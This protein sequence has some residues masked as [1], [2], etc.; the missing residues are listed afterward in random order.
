MSTATLAAEAL[1]R[2]HRAPNV[3]SQ[4]WGTF[5]EQ[6]RGAYGGTLME[7][8]A[9]HEVE[10]VDVAKGTQYIFTTLGHPA[11]PAWISRRTRLWGGAEQLDQ[12][13]YFAGSLKQFQ[14]WFEVWRA[15]PALPAPPHGTWHDP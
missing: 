13:G 12:V 9:V 15:R 10:Y 6:V 8:P 4:D 7:R 11:H 14:A 5:H 2:P 3:T 1:F